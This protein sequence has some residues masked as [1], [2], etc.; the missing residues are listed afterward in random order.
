MKELIHTRNISIRCYETGGKGMLVEGSLADERLFPFFLYSAN[1]SRDPGVIH[2]MVIRM[3]LSLP[4]LT[5]LAADAGMPVVPVSQCREIAES[6]RK[7]VG[8]RIKPG[9]TNE[10]RR[11]FAKKAGCLHLT[12][13]ILAMSSAAVQGEWSYYSRKRQDDHVEMPDMDGSMIIDSCWLWREDGPLAARFRKNRKD[14]KAPKK[15]LLITIDGPAGAG[16]STVARLLAEKLSYAC[17]ETGALYR[18]LAYRCIQEGISAEDERAIEDFCARFRIVL[19]GKAGSMRILA[20]GE[21]VT[22]KIRSESVGLLASTLSAM[23]PV[24]ATLLDVQRDAGKEGGVI[25]EGRDMGTVVFP[26]ADFK[27]FLEARTDERI[28]RRRRELLERGDEVSRRNV[29]SDIVARDRQDRERK[30]SPLKVPADAVVIDS[31]HLSAE[32]VVERILS[33]LEVERSGS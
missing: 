9:F 1:E 2:R 33:S 19:R 16:K 29:E 11:L 23:P 13:L 4:E 30:I 7:L 31:T 6:V 27:F 20:D 12:N 5:I 22:D 10:V 18:A 28:E 24:R 17:L 3:T 15:G 26:A 14:E 25:A 21:D 32:E 8:L